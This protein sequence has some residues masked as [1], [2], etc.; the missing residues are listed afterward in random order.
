MS[1]PAEGGRGGSGRRGRARQ[2][3]AP[4]ARLTTATYTAA[5][6]CSDY[7]ERPIYARPL[8]SALRARCS[9]KLVWLVGAV[10]LALGLS[11]P[12]SVANAR[13]AKSEAVIACYHE[14]IDRFTR[15]VHPGQC[16][17][18]GYRGKQF[19]GIPVRGMK[20]GH[21][22]ANPTR[23][24][25]GVDMRDGTRVRVIA[26]RPIS[27]GGGRAW[28]SRVVVVS[29]VDGNGFELRLPTCDDSHLIGF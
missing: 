20:W 8:S 3:R 27:C 2:F 14:K 18:W 22:G 6:G 28:Y 10:S 13:T 9:V 25:Y 29:L 21:W 11:G 19:V 4:D 23:A 26:Y 15:Q 24:A 12:P 1:E 16:N 17:I 5:H 7:A